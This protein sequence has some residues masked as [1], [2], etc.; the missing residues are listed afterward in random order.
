MTEKNTQHQYYKG[1]PGRFRREV[2]RG[3]LGHALHFA[4][5]F[6]CLAFVLACGAVT[7]GSLVF[8]VGDKSL[9]SFLALVVSGAIF[10]WLA[11]GLWAAWFQ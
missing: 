7:L 8:F 2:E 3:L 11:K 10:F 6:V 5:R 1:Y 4:F 9:S